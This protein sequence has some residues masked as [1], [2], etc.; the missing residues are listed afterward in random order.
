MNI[1]IFSLLLFLMLSMFSVQALAQT[2][3][4]GFDLRFG[5]GAP[6]T[7]DNIDVKLGSA[8]VFKEHGRSRGFSTNISLGWRWKYVGLYFDQELGNLWH[9][10]NTDANHELVSDISNKNRF[11]GATYLLVRA[12]YNFS[13]EFL[14]SG[15]F[16]IGAI[17][18]TEDKLWYR[19][20][21]VKGKDLFESAALKVL[22]EATFFVTSF[23]GLGLSFEFAYA[24]ATQDFWV[25][26]PEIPYIM[27]H[28]VTMHHHIYIIQ[29][30]VHVNFIF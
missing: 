10:S 14:I 17:Y 26:D 19:F 2:D 6:V 16:G 7:Y 27:Q 23:I 30:G 4:R 1:R 13:P 12:F 22:F 18:G 29:P 8:R 28:K 3:P 15:G 25:P 11:I 20:P 21:N 9:T 24:N 5:I